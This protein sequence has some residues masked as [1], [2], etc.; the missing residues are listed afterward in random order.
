MVSKFLYVEKG[1]KKRNE[2][3]K[4]RSM[5]VL[6]AEARHHWLHSIKKVT[7]RR[8]CITIRELSMGFME[9]QPD[10]AEKL[11]QISKTYI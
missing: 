10:V 9:E 7:E 5:L 1:F 8:L 6:S 2:K 11:F 3:L 4:N